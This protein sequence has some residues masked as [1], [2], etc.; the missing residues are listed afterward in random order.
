MSK[1]H[2]VMDGS[3]QL[4]SPRSIPPG[5]QPTSFGVI[6]NPTHA[7]VDELVSLLRENDKM[8]IYKLQINISN[9]LVA[10]YF[11]EAGGLKILTKTIKSCNGN[12]LA[13]GLVTFSY[14]LDQ[15]YCPNNVDAILD[16]IIQTIIEEPQ[17]NVVKASLSTLINLISHVI[18]SADPVGHACESSFTQLLHSLTSHDEFCIALV[19]KLQSSE[20]QVVNS[21][22]QLINLI[23][24]GAFEDKNLIIHQDFDNNNNNSSKSAEYWSQLFIQIQNSRLLDA[25]SGLIKSSPNIRQ[26]SELGQ[27][28]STCQIL[29]R[30]LLHRWQQLPTNTA[31]YKSHRSLLDQVYNLAKQQVMI[32]LQH[33]EH[34]EFIWQRLGVTNFANPGKDFASSGLIGLSNL[35]DYIQSIGV[36]AFKTL[37]HQQ[38]AQSNLERQCPIIKASIAVTLLLIDLLEI[39]TADQIDQQQQPEPEPEPEQQN[40]DDDSNE[41]FKSQSGFIVFQWFTL[42]TEGLNLFI[43]IWNQS[44]ARTATSDLVHIEQ[45][46]FVTEDFD[47]VLDLVWVMFK[48]LKR[49]IINDPRI[50][51]NI[52]QFV[53]Q[54]TYADLR[55]LQM[56][57]INQEQ[58]QQWQSSFEPD[59]VKL[60][61]SQLGQEVLQFVMDQRINCLL[62]G[63]WFLNNPP[64]SLAAR[65]TVQQ[66]QPQQQ[67]FSSSPRRSRDG[68]L[69]NFDGSSTRT[70]STG[71][72]S[73]S[74]STATNASNAWT[75]KNYWKFVQL[76]H[77]R[78]QLHWG[79]F[80]RKLS[81]K[82]RPSLDEL[83][84]VVDLTAVSVIQVSNNVELSQLNLADILD[85]A[86][87]IKSDF[88]GTSSRSNASFPPSSSPAS[89]ATPVSSAPHSVL[90]TT[91]KINNSKFTFKLTLQGYKSN[92]SPL[93]STEATLLQVYPQ[94]IASAAEWYDGLNILLS[95]NGFGALSN[96]MHNLHKH[97]DDLTDNTGSIRD[98]RTSQVLT[99]QFTA[100]TETVKYIKMITGMMMN[101]RM[102]NVDEVQTHVVHNSAIKQH[103]ERSN[104]SKNTAIEF[105]NPVSEI[106]FYD[107][108]S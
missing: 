57:Y 7:D 50:F 96:A 18:N 88:D 58:Q 100:S 24:S 76:S 51:Q 89:I 92:I 20:N 16:K 36:P 84:G 33:S 98:R 70:P 104:A 21:T 105:T 73:A 108:I 8:G 63:A 12:T 67:V 27:S 38:W 59:Q 41:F 17:V 94:T 79:D 28:V 81:E 74:T 3:N 34:A 53:Q 102:L 60:L 49:S 56:T 86:P 31:D 54:I 48:H 64:D 11:V 46:Q 2:P 91:G 85:L 75:G 9:S 39:K 87:S 68:D 103:D 80:D 45:S 15:G 43:K 97:D 72:A 44:R 40:S 66:P 37:L 62:K 6:D 90:M 99:D 32:V 107:S 95:Q 82:Q 23:L 77:N 22:I 61:K 42:H 101:V 5:S 35:S 52:S 1:S 69:L 26:G 14:L 25:I 93:S 83:A 4:S 71:S 106:F 13:Y 78:R 30:K 55:K 10:N 47:K 19:T 29:I 65:F